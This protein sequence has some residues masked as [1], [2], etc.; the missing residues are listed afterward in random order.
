MI[1]NTIIT[2]I[3]ATTANDIYEEQTKRLEK[4]IL[5]YAVL[6]AIAVATQ[7]KILTIVMATC[8]CF[9]KFMIYINKKISRDYIK[10]KILEEQE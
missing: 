7:L 9:T 6:L 4:M 3:V 10:T 1:E 2:T 5:M 8:L